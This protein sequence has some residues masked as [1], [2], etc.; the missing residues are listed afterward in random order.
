M[1]GV[2]PA[3]LRGA[4]SLECKLMFALAAVAAA[5]AALGL[6]LDLLD[7]HY[8]R[9]ARQDAEAFWRARG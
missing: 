6:A 1:D 8:A 2:A 3:P 5:L 4:F 9:L 7:V